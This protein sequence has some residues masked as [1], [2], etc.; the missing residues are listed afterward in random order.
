MYA[1]GGSARVKTECSGKI[2]LGIKESQLSGEQEVAYRSVK[3][4][5]FHYWSD[6]RLYRLIRQPLLVDKDSVPS[7]YLIRQEKDAAKFLLLEYDPQ[8]PTDIGMYDLREAQ[9]SHRKEIRYMPFVTT[10]ESV[11]QKVD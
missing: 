3:Y 8:L 2:A 11:Q 7:D 5:L 1:I 6:P 9:R 4:L 10:L